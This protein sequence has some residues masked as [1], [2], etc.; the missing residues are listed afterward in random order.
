M[1]R[2]ESTWLPARAALQPTGLYLELREI[3]PEQLQDPFLVETVQRVP[4]RQSVI[5]ILKQDLGRAS[6]NSAPAGLI[7]HVGRCGSTVASQ[8]LKHHDQVVVYSEPIA[9]NEI[10]VPPRKWDR[11]E[12]VAALRSLGDLLARHAGKPYVLKLSSWN[13]L[14][15][16]IVSDAFPSTP[17]AFCVRDPLEVC[18]SLLQQR[19][20]WLRDAGSRS[21]LLAG[22]ADAETCDAPE[23]YLPRLLAAYCRAIAGL[24]PHRGKLIPYETLPE[25]V[26]STL[27]PHFGL[28]IGEEA[29]ARMT[30][31]S[32]TY[33]KSRVG[34]SVAFVSDGAGKRAAASPEL[35]RAVD[36]HARPE[37]ERL[38]AALS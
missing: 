5:Q 32:R 28:S 24:D 12:L 25:A 27:A 4:A 31:A 35:R 8:L 17:W 21:H 6:P 13:T 38:V 22:I 1:Q 19:P 33:A 29:R 23:E 10:L 9:L 7:F 16:D 3:G 37:L 15:C 36:S 14:S 26:W 30:A 2:I 20:G 11:P 34:Q 18:V